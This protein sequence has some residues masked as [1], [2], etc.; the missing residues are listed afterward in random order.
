MNPNELRAAEASPMAL[1][2]AENTRPLAV[3]TDGRPSRVVLVRAIH[4]STG[5]PRSV[6][7]YEAIT[8]AL[9]RLNFTGTASVGW[10]GPYP[11]VVRKSIPGGF[12]THVAWL[13]QLDPNAAT[14]NDTQTGFAQR[15][16]AHEVA[17]ALAGLTGGET[18]ESARQ[19]SDT[20]VYPFNVAN[21]GPRA[22][23]ESGY[24]ARTRTRDREPAIT[25]VDMQ[26]NP[27][28][29][30]AADLQNP[31]YL[32]WAAQQAGG[33]VGGFSWGVV[34]GG[35]AA[36]VGA[37]WLLAKFG[38]SREVVIRTDSGRRWGRR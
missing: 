14:H 5:L 11:R 28:G 29:P 9:R 10:I 1:E 24:A 22:W 32:S 12:E 19:W 26:E 2:W 38:G 31:D 25:D 4:Q 16:L 7:G 33:A 20:T 36:F 21:H 8:E 3:D 18:A 6:L 30:D 15:R 23:W 17:V 13:H 34:A 35:A 27:L 37:M